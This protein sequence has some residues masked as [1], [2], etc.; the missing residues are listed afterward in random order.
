MARIHV[1]VSGRSG[2]AHRPAARRGPSR[3]SAVPRHGND[4]RSRPWWT[5]RCSAS[6]CWRCCR[7]SSPRSALDARGGRP[8]RRAELFGR[9]ADA[10]NWRPSGARRLSSWAWSEPSSRTSASPRSSARR[11]GLP[12]GLYLSRFVE[13]LLFDV[14]PF[15]DLNLGLP[16]T[17]LFVAALLGC[18]LCPRFARR[19]SI[20]SSRSGR[21]RT[22]SV[23]RRPA[24][25][26]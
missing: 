26:Y 12:G 18:R 10:R 16:L 14:R 3:R 8:L 19:A 24:S 22:F 15:D 11:L 20:R 17:A 5:G 2:G 21:T 1:R 9:A 23:H 13:T 6:V 4:R 7:D 25:A